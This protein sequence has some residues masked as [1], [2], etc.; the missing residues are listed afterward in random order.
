MAQSGISSLEMLGK[1][2][3]SRIGQQR[4]GGGPKMQNE[5]LMQTLCVHA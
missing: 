3:L 1:P 5:L 4:T 2:P